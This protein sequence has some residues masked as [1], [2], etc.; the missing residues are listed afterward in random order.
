MPPGY[1]GHPMQM[2]PGSRPSPN[3]NP[4]SAAG[5]PPP[6]SS[7]ASPSPST[8]GMPFPGGQGQFPYHPNA[9]KGY[10]IS[11]LTFFLEHLTTFTRHLMI[12]LLFYCFCDPAI[13]A[14]SLIVNLNFIPT[15]APVT[16]QSIQRKCSTTLEIL[17][18]GCFRSFFNVVTLPFH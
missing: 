5:A 12:L 17:I 6:T 16:W 14:V 7:S 15:L 3:Q 1:M 8:V 2:P 13:P 18:Q 10:V 11:S 4:S 9:P